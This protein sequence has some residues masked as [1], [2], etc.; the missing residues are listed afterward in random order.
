MSETKQK[1]I[2]EFEK[3]AVEKVK[4][5]F[6][7]FRGQTYCDIRVFFLDDEKV[8]H[9]TKKGVCLNVELLGELKKA[10]DKA[11]AEMEMGEGEEESL[12]SEGMVERH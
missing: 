2:A 8:E 5:H 6:Q 10:V 11:L 7:E 12:G 9:A 3:N 1:L 4:V